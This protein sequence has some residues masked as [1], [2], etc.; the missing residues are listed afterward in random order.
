MQTTKIVVRAVMYAICTQMLY[1]LLVL[2]VLVL[3]QVVIQVLATVM[4]FYQTDVKLIQ[5]LTN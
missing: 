3:F 4:V 2:K 1:Q 5:I